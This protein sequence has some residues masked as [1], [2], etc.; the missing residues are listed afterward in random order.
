[1]FAETWRQILGVQHVGMDDNFFELGGHSLAATQIMARICQA[2]D[3]EL[4]LRRLYEAPTVAA[5]AAALLQVSAEPLT[6]EKTAEL[7][8]KLAQLSE[9]QVDRMLADKK[10][11]RETNNR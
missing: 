7:L 9:D 10:A 3:V 5:L 6:I 2:F 1:V 4:P 8:L 11:A